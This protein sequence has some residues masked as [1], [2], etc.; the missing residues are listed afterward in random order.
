MSWTLVFL[1]VSCLATLVWALERTFA[2]REAEQALR[3]LEA[4]RALER[5]QTEEEREGIRG[6]LQQ[7]DDEL[8]RFVYTVS[9]DLKSPMVTLHGFLGLLK[10]DLAAGQVER[11]ELD[12]E[13]I[14]SA[15]VTM[16]H[17]LEDLLE[18]SRIGRMFN[19]PETIPLTDAAREA[20]ERVAERLAESGARVEIAEDMPTI[21]ADRPRILQVLQHLIDNAAKFVGD[22][23][24]RKIEIGGHVDGDEIV[25]FVRDNGIGIDPRFHERVFG[26]FNRLDKSRGGTGI[27]LTLVERIMAVHDGRVWVESDGEGHGSAFYIA[28]PPRPKEI[29]TAA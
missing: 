6:K 25:C 17:L 9:H 19:L 24:D 27:G 23:A 16:Q 8:K 12:V 14:Q 29:Q 13:R 28:L 20:A 5:R 2:V 1:M 4:K 7:K 10:Q 22:G 3:Q 26:L 21:V 11:V 18:L 15:A